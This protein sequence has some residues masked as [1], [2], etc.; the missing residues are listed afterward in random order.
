LFW[1]D[2]KGNAVMM[3]H[4]MEQGVVA[5]AFAVTME[6]ATGSEKPTSP[7]LIIGQGL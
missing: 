6:D 7:I 5:K 2:E 1:P 4:K 3:D